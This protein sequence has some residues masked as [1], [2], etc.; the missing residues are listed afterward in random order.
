MLAA[1]F[2]IAVSA[3]IVVQVSAN[4]PQGYMAAS[5]NILGMQAVRNLIKL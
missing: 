3:G 1:L 5:V 2:V 4:L